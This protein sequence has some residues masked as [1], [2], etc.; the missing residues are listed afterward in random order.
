MGRINSCTIHLATFVPLVLAQDQ[1]DRRNH[2]QKE[3]AYGS[4]SLSSLVVDVVQWAQV[5]HV[6]PTQ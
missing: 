4:N 1:A 2:L 6:Q 5:Q 3:G